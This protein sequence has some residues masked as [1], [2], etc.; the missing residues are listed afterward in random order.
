[1]TCIW[2]HISIP[3]CIYIIKDLILL[4]VLKL[5]LVWKLYGLKIIIFVPYKISG[6]LK[7]LNKIRYRIFCQWEP[8]WNNL[9]I[10]FSHLSELKNLYLHNNKIENIENLTC[11]KNLTTLNL[12]S[13]AIGKLNPGSISCLPNLHTLLISR[14]KLRTAEDIEELSKCSSEVEC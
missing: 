1:M 11:L 13:N 8:W 5:I 7:C 9:L 2:H 6:K 14:N 12:S 4:K 10:Y 3:Y